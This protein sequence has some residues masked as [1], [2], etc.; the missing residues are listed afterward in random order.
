ML[1]F[2]IATRR[3][4]TFN[5]SP[6]GNNCTDHDAFGINRSAVFNPDFEFVSLANDHTGRAVRDDPDAGQFGCDRGLPLRQLSGR[7]AAGNRSWFRRCLKRCL[8]K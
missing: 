7:R 8:A 1:I 2:N 3:R 5:V 6:I 4:L